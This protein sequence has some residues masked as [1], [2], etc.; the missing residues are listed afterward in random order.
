M[1][2]CWTRASASTTPR[3]PFPSRGF[4]GR[5]APERAAEVTSYLEENPEVGEVVAGL[6]QQYDAFT[7]AQESGE[8]LLAVEGDLPTGD[9]IGEQFERFLAGLD[10]SDDA[11]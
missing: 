5:F 1:G 10:E 8:G 3:R 11:S 4:N 2:S 6:E 9:E 7:R